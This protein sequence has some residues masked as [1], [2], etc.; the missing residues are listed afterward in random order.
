MAYELSG[1]LAG[2]ISLNTGEKVVPACGGEPESFLR[3]VV[4]PLYTVISEVLHRLRQCAMFKAHSH[5]L[6]FNVLFLDGPGS[7]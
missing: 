5:A 3:N 7:S 2:S 4:T 6:Q 1:V